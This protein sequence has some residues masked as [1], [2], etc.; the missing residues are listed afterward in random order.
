MRNL[1]QVQVSYFGFNSPTTIF[2][3]DTEIAGI[4]IAIATLELRKQK[5]LQNAKVA[6][7]KASEQSPAEKPAPGAQQPSKVPEQKPVQKEEA[8]NEQSPA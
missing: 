8:K 2:E 3:V 7:I 1:E 4:D 6:R 5:L